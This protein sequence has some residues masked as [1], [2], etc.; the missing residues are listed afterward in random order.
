MSHDHREHSYLALI[1]YSRRG[2][3]TDYLLLVVDAWGGPLLALPYN[4]AESPIDV[5]R[6]HYRPMP[7]MLVPIQITPGQR[8][9]F[10][11]EYGP[12]AQ[13]RPDARSIAGALPTAPEPSSSR[14]VAR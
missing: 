7:V 8:A 13:P 4:V 11:R 5:L 3:R 9:V 14:G 10:L 1:L 12:F 2:P 6:E